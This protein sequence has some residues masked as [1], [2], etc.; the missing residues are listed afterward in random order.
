[1][2][3]TRDGNSDQFGHVFQLQLDHGNILERRTFCRAA[4]G[5]H[6]PDYRVRQ[7]RVYRQQLRR[8]PGMAVVAII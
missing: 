2:G 5:R 7:V 1:M 6:V 4:N 3:G 8:N